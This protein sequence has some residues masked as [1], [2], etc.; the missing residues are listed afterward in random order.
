MVSILQSGL[1]TTSIPVSER[2]KEVK[3]LDLDYDNLPIEGSLGVEWYL[4]S[5]SFR[6]KL[7]LKQQPLTRRGILSIVINKQHI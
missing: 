3:D 4:N 5:D 6:F 1:A 7:D 2:A